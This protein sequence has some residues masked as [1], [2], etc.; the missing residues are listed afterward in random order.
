MA[1]T[2]QWASARE[3]SQLLSRSAEE[4]KPVLLDM[5]SSECSGCRNHDATIYSNPLVAREIAE[6]TLPVRVQTHNPDQANTAI[7]DNHIYIWS[8]TVQL[9]ASDATRYHEFNGAPRRTRLSVGYQTVFHDTPGHLTPELFHAQLRVARGKAALRTNDH[10]EAMRLFDSVIR[11]Y[12]TDEIAV[13]DAQR[14]LAVA[15]SDGVVEDSFDGRELTTLS[16]L[17]RAV[18]RFAQVVAKLP[19][20]VLMRDWIGQPGSGGWEWYSDCLKEVVLQAYQELCDFGV[21]ADRERAVHGPVM[22]DAHRILG[23][24]RLAYREFQSLWIGVPDV[25]LDQ[26]PLPWERSLRENLAHVIMAEWWAF[27]PLVLGALES[28]RK[29]LDPKIVEASETVAA[30]GEPPGSHETLGELLARYERLHTQNSQDFSEITDSELG[31]RSAWWENGPV[32]LR[33]RL[34]RYVWHPR[35]HSAYIDKIL[36][37]AGHRRTATQRFAAR[38]FSGLGVAE[39]PLIGAGE[40]LTSR[41]LD[42]AQSIEERA[43]EAERLLDIVT[44]EAEARRA[45]ES[46][47]A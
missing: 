3:F 32:D 1:A 8:P 4:G 6:H 25:L 16:P 31:M 15:K 20:S 41:Y 5:H 10:R 46:K 11:Q 30:H 24:H 13:A 33:F 29:G 2:V 22:T 42:L 45:H 37:V 19:D 39:G 27:R 14:W 38:L 43:D 44:A 7:I 12:P 18:E 9:L 35:D 21:V 26:Y 40:L 28:G 17:A 34:K 36:D 23:Q 47:V